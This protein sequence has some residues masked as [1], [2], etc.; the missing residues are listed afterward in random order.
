MQRPLVVTLTLNPAVDLSGETERLLPQHK[1]RCVNERRDAG[2]GGINVARVL[3]RLGAHPLAV[4]PVAGVTGG[5]LEKLVAEEGVRHAAIPGGGETRENVTVLETL[6]GRQY[7]FVFPGQP[8]ST[9]DTR[10]C[11][12]AALLSLT[13]GGWLVASGSL[14]PGCPVDTYAMLAR[15]TAAT[16]AFFALDASGEP[17]RRALAEP[18]DL[19]KLSESELCSLSDGELRDTA[20]CIAAAKAVLAAGVKMVAVTR[21]EKGALLISE[22]F[23]LEATAPAIQIISTV[24]AGDSFLSALIW[25]LS[26]D[27][28][29]EESLRTAIA[30]GSAALTS[31]GTDLC[32]A[33]TM[34]H[35]RPHV[36]ICALG[37]GNAFQEPVV[38]GRMEYCL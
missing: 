17:L 33:E 9:W 6:T 15:M 20:A 11:C 3:Q 32:R 29:P 34:W 10:K 37:H 38:H 22:G 19:L 5:R 31:P 4:F 16:G 14:P 18:I 26:R 12:D 30:A 1:L 24:G 2:G 23:V 8:L 25:E 35:L 27:S 13:P 7:R 36:Q 21:A 28:R